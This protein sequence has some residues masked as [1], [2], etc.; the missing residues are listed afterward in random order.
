MAITDIDLTERLD[1]MIFPV[2]KATYDDKLNC[3]GFELFG[4]AFLI[5]Q[6]GFALTAGHVIENIK[7]SITNPKH[8]AKHEAIA[9]IFKDKNNLKYA[10]SIQIPSGTPLEEEH[11][12][13]DVSIFKLDF[14][15]DTKLRPPFIIENG[16][17]L[18]AA[19][20][21]SVGYPT[22]LS[23]DNHL[24]AR[25]PDGTLI[26]DE[27]NILTKGYIKRLVNYGVG[28]FK[29]NKFLELSEVGTTGYS[30]A[31]IVCIEATKFSLQKDNKI[32]NEVVCHRL[33]GIYIGENQIE[34]GD[35]HKI[36]CGYAASVEA[37]S[38]WKPSIANGKSLQQIMMVLFDS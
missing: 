12:S 6:D 22:Y 13:H 37:F 7:A 33:L 36:S 23:F 25:A 28:K 2:G 34:L 30:G 15:P 4:T 14:E 29:G 21:Y 35:G 19:D 11:P 3:T 1:N 8:E 16:F 24:K 32:I 26:P 20:F 17:R 10:C 38:N 27:I 9:G 18:S 31:P 5:G